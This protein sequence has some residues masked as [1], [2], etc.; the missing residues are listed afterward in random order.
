[1]S[2]ELDK[3]KQAWKDEPIF[4][5][6]ILSENDISHFIKAE[7]HHT[8][9]IYRGGLM[10]DL[11]FKIL[12]LICLF[13]LILTMVGSAVKILSSILFLVTLWGILYQWKMYRSIPQLNAE[14]SNTL[15]IIQKFLIFHRQYSRSIFISALSASLFFIVGSMIYLY[16]KYGLIPEFQWDD[17]IVMTIGIV[18]SY[19]FSAFSQWRQSNQLLGEWE[20]CKAELENESFNEQQ[21]REIRNKQSRNTIFYGLLLLVGL[22]FL[23]L[24][25]LA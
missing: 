3:Y 14:D 22:I 1:M 16:L 11:A 19:G 9:R 6:P 12:L 25:F 7:S 13:I 15:G 8:M 20:L 5:E 4:E 10:F 24:L 21:I 2:F 18:L 17:F 23:M